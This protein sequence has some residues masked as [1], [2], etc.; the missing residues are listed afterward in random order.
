[1]GLIEIVVTVCA[2]TQPNMCEDKHL[3]FAAEVSLN[4]CVMGAQPYVAK[5][6][7]EHPSW[8]LKKYRCEYPQSRDKA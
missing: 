1:V 5:W 7:S 3:Q 2:V 6:I 4:Q 8:T